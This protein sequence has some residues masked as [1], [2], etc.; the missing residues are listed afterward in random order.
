MATG[1]EALGAASAVLQVISFASDVVIACKKIY[2]GKPTSEVCLERHSK[3]MSDAVGRL[4]TRCEAM[5]NV[6]S[7][8]GNQKLQDIAKECKKAA[9]DLER[10]A[11]SITS[12]H[13]K[14][15]ILKA[16]HATFRVSSHQKKIQRLELSL[17]RYRQILET[18]LMSHLCSR[19]DA[20]SLQQEDSFQNLAADV[21]RLI[22]Q[23]AQGQTRIKD[24]IKEESGLVRDIIMRET[25]RTEGA[26][27]A[28]T[29]TQALTFKTAAEAQARCDA[30]LKSLKFPQMKERYNAIMDSGDATFERVFASYDNP[31]TIR[32]GHK[33]SD[34]DIKE[35][36]RSWALFVAWLQSDASL[37]YI[38]GKP[39]SG[40]STLVKFIVDNNK[41]ERLVK[42]WSP[43]ILIISHY[44]WKIGVSE[45]NSIKGLLYSLLYQ[46]LQ[47][48][49]QLIHD[50]LDH[51]RHLLSHTEYHDW[52]LKDLDS[53]LHY[54][55]NLD[56]RHTCIFIDGIDEIRNQDGFSKLLQSIEK[57]LS[58]P[59]T[60][61]CIS[62]RPEP[63]VVRWL[64]MKKASG[65]LLEDLTKP[66]MRLFVREKLQ[67]LPSS[68]IIS[69][70][71][72]RTL[73]MILADKAQGVFLWLYL[74]TQS[75]IAGIEN[76][77]SDDLLVARMYELPRELEDLYTDM[78][79]RFNENNSV[80]REI[81]ARYFYYA[82]QQWRIFYGTSK[83]NGNGHVGGL[84]GPTL[85]QVACAEDME[86]QEILLSDSGTIDSEETQRLCDRA[87]A[88][89]N[90]RCAGL[91]QVKSWEFSKD[92][93]DIRNA[94]FSKVVFIHRTAYDFLMD[95]ETGQTILGSNLLS[96]PAVHTRLLKGLICHAVAHDLEWGLTVDMGTIFNEIIKLSEGW[97]SE[98][99]QAAFNLLHI[100]QPFYDKQRIRSLFAPRIAHLPFLCHFM[101]YDQFD[102]FIISSVAKEKSIDL[103]TN[104]LRE[105][106]IPKSV[107]PDKDHRVPSSRVV[108]A[109]I[110]LG[111]DPHKYGS[112]QRL[113]RDMI[114]FV[115]KGTAF[116]NLLMRF[117]SSTEQRLQSINSVDGWVL[118]DD[119]SCETLK[120]A[121]SMA[122][123]C[124]NLDSTVLLVGGFFESG[125]MI[126][127]PIW[128]LNFLPM[129]STRC[130]L[131]EANL[132]FL[133]LHL[134]SKHRGDLAK[135]ILRGS[136]TQELLPRLRN[137]SVKLRLALTIHLGLHPSG[138]DFFNDIKCHRIPL[139]S[140]VFSPA[141][142]RY[143][144]EAVLE[145][146]Y[147]KLRA[148]KEGETDLDIV[149]K[150]AQD[151]N[152][153]EVGFEAAILALAVEELGFCTF[154]E[155]DT[156][157]TAWDLKGDRKRFAYPLTMK[158][159][160]M[161][162]S[163]Q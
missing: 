80:Y 161:T 81:A 23:L 96:I 146:D 16:V 128:R 150:V 94:V 70:E 61:L 50:T 8:F 93:S 106:W 159:L 145:S 41:T 37:F 27:N 2:D 124:Q 78:W 132:Q 77:D 75:L 136:Q 68:H 42:H 26:I 1:L 119:P 120:T 102:D 154:E 99:L 9:E 87:K 123:T 38:R 7:K 144:L 151:R 44:F 86:T 134:L 138:R 147:E 101:G 12:L 109:L 115:S 141:S 137:P 79:Q 22:V 25:A 149:T 64:H 92:K 15:S 133:L 43:D 152:A 142:T 156:K 114:P 139:E 111:A 153:E 85:F 33:S 60:K 29:A 47:S 67:S 131:L 117:I 20:I 82:L 65:I 162:V 18:E 125:D 121:I 118:A 14:G 34:D 130:V 98:G 95:T 31:R 135:T 155:S 48:N 21:Q 19:S 157:P 35:I 53:V 36:D 66:D 71:T 28:Y 55:S 88:S 148:T 17:S 3:Q 76:D 91:L 51:F 57:I 58:L 30:F 13:V 158:Q 59:K 97:G 105:S 84:D 122:K 56:A 83:N 160:E 116:T 103:A 113:S 72:S 11:Q 90:I 74:A 104:V 126:A 127:L 129:T 40:K 69:T 143:Q 5:A 39:G 62:T 108:E 4:E 100:M 63:Q 46:R 140:S 24:L 32:W 49:Q 54:V 6:H 52:S 107:Y 163:R 10:E 112:N 89:I 73:S 45:Q 110:S